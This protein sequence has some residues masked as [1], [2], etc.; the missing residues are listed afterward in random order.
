MTVGKSDA[1]GPLFGE[2][3][4]RFERD[5]EWSFPKSISIGW[6]VEKPD[7]ATFRDYSTRYY[8]ASQSICAMIKNNDVEDYV[9]SFPVIYLVRHSIELGLKGAILNQTG[10]SPFG[11]KLNKLWPNVQG[12][13]DWALNWI[14]EF[15]DLDM[16]SDALRYPDSNVNTF[17]V[18]ALLDDWETKTEKLHSHLMMLCQEQRTIGIRQHAK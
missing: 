10:K 15:H 3:D 2:V 5:D 9:V 1:Y 4:E 18:G 8:R 12:L 7:V 13:S 11:H 6:P 14:K 17:E 16:K